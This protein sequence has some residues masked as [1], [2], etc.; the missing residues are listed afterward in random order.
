MC[1]LCF[2]SRPWLANSCLT[3]HCCRRVLYLENDLEA[4]AE[5]L[6]K[7]KDLGIE[8]SGWKAQLDIASGQ[9]GQWCWLC[10]LGTAAAG[11][12]AA[13]GSNSYIGW[14]GW[15]C[16]RALAVL[17]RPDLIGVPMPAAAQ[18]AQVLEMLK[19]EIDEIR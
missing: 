18:M 16:D 13:H 14:W 1:L 6:E 8:L 5:E 11:V 9:V 4:H 19:Q 15:F 3:V 2:F 10:W 7:L 12:V 17:W